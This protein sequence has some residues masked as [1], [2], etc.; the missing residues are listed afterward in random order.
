MY[1]EFVEVASKCMGAGLIDDVNAFA[2]LRS[3]AGACPAHRASARSLP[4]LQICGGFDRANCAELFRYP[5]LSPEPTSQGDGASASDDA[6]EF[7][8]R[9]LGIDLSLRR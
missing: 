8:K 5:D 6:L 7:V 2:A 1:S 3:K 4:G 9:C